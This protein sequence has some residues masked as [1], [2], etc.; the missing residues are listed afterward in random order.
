[1]YADI[2]VDISHENLDRVYQYRIPEHLSALVFIGVQVYIPFGMSNRKIKGYVIGL[3]KT[4]DYDENKIKEIHSVVDKSLAIENKLIALAGFIRQNF[5]GTMNDALKVV[6]PIK[7]SIKAVEKKSVRLLIT[8]EKLDE[9]IEF[10]TKKHNLARVRLLECFK[11]NSDNVS[12]NYEYLTKTKNISTPVL[13][14]FQE[15]GV[16]KIEAV[17]MYRNPINMGAQTKKEQ[18]VLNA[19]QSFILSSFYDD[20]INGIRKTYLLH[21]ITGSGKTCVYIEM[22][23]KV[24]EVGKKVIVLIP[25][26]ALT[27]QTV[28]RFYSEFGDRISIMNSRLSSGER[29]DQY[30][31]ARNG[32]IDIMIG[33]RSALFT[34]FENLGLIIMDEEHESSY[35]SD[36][37]CKYHAREVAIKRAEIEGASVVLGSAT[38][39]M[40][41]YYRAM[42]REYTLF[43]MTKRA[44]AS[45]ILPKVHIV[46]LREELKARNKS[47]F[48]RKLYELIDDRLR[49]KEQIML[50][51]NRRGYSGFVSCRSCGYVVKCPH[52]DVSL[53][54]HNTKI[55]NRAYKNDSNGKLVCHYCGYE[56]GVLNTCPECN[57]DYI[58]LFGTGTQKIEELV[59][60][61]FP[62]A[63]VLRMDADTTHGK[64]GH[65]QI[66]SQFDKK[67]AD[68]LVGTQMIVKGHDFANVTLV[69]ILAADLSLNTNDYRAAERTY[70]L[71]TQAAGRAGRG[72]KLGEVVVQTYRPMHY[73][74]TTAAK[75]DYKGFYE[76]EINYRE[77]MKYPPAADIMVLLMVAK[78]YELV[79]KMSKET[80]SIIKNLDCYSDEISIIGPAD[81]SLSKAKDFF[82]KVLYLKSSNYVD[83]VKIKDIVEK[84]SRDS[85]EYKRCTMYIDFN[86]INIY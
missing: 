26:I 38:P 28:N 14:Y 33:P 16:I 77:L 19:E 59:K 67:E 46:D 45:A 29:Y 76:K 83:L 23:K 2:I 65:Q 11:N 86:P 30:L 57:S 8:N 35:K 56:T 53:T 73:S 25:E 47:I 72:D 13:K 55:S 62:A 58:A 82:R 12:I 81:A 39:S 31:R 61:T 78:D 44:V 74:I 69:G 66:L 85:V 68:I 70:Q 21:G 34:P 3:S 7:S 54:F 63:R 24:L 42:N 84:W 15:Q 4:T 20:Y 1:M 75:S 80:V 60:R 37:S 36:T 32:D 41:A 27:Y 64:E 17:T 10:N 5:G 50:F 43:E 49:K 40:E 6:M 18:V 22:I 51:I 9:L 52:C 48:S 71:I 79:D